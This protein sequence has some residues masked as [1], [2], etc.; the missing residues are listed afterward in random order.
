LADAELYADIPR[1]IA[2]LR[3]LG[4]NHPFLFY[5]KLG[6]VVTGGMPDAKWSRSARHLH[7]QAGPSE[8]SRLVSRGSAAPLDIREEPRHLLPTLGRRSQW[9]AP[10]PTSRCCKAPSTC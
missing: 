1:H 4:R 9:P 2:E 5:R 10:P 3:D 7:V 8:L 6:F